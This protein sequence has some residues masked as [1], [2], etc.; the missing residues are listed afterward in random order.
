MQIDLEIVQII[1]VRLHFVSFRSNLGGV[2]SVSCSNYRCPVVGVNKYC[3]VKVHRCLMGP[4]VDSIGNELII[5]HSVMTAILSINI[6]S[7]KVVN[8]K[9]NTTKEI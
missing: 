3:L 4:Y 1:N 6:V 9:F 8:A 5:M 2:L 7:R